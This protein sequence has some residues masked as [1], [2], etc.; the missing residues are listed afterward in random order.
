MGLQA[1]MSFRSRAKSGSGLTDARGSFTLRHSEMRRG[2]DSAGPI[3]ATASPR[4]SITASL[5]FSTWSNR[6]EKSRA[7]C[8]AV[9]RKI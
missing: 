5:P 9:S 3:T 1:T 4:R 8:V 7:A 6:P 2:A